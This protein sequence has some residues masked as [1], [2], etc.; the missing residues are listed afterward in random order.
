MHDA[1]AMSQMANCPSGRSAAGAE[2]CCPFPAGL[3]K[4]CLSYEHATLPAN[5]HFHEP[6]PNNAGL[7]DGILKVVTQPTDFAKGVVALSNFGF[8]GAT[9]PRRMPCACKPR[10]D[11][12]QCSQSALLCG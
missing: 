9:F 3:I 7:K 5:L 1:Q 10:L 12:S 11:I 6:N 2:L 4:V 8:G